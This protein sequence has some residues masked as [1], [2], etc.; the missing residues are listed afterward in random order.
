MTKEK[1]ETIVSDERAFIENTLEEKAGIRYGEEPNEKNKRKPNRAVLAQLRRTLGK[2]PNQAFEAFP[3]ISEATCD[4]KSEWDVRCYY[5]VAS[6]FALYQQ[7][8]IKRSWHH[9]PNPEKQW[10]DLGASFRLLELAMQR[11]NKEA[12]PNLERSKSLEKRFTALL[13]SRSEDLSDRLRHAVLLLKS[14]DVPIDWVQ[15]LRD[16]LYWQQGER[17][18]RLHSKSKSTQR[19]WAQSFWCVHE[20]EENAEP[21]TIETEDISEKQ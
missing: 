8:G 6:L 20:A 15:L 12:T 5:L 4:L 3:Y 2:H 13:S 10:R 1:T 14:Y 18:I 17:A 7:G 11:K 21:E 16:L 9:E 19:R